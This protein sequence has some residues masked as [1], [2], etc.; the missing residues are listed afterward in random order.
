MEYFLSES[1]WIDA[2]AAGMDAALARLIP[3]IRDHPRD[4]P[5]SDSPVTPATAVRA[6]EASGL[7]RRNWRV[8]TIV[9]AA[10]VAALGWLLADRFRIPRHVLEAEPADAAAPLASTGVPASPAIAAQY[11]AV[12]PFADMARKRIR[13]TSPTA[14]RRKSSIC[15]PRFLA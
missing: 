10:V 15:L 5:A 8:S 13:S 12:L 3:A 1:Q 2:R 4:Q 11:I 6:A 9:A 14:W 7:L